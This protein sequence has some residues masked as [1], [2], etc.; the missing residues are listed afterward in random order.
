MDKLRRVGF[1]IGIVCVAYILIYA[2]NANADSLQVYYLDDGN[3]GVTQEC[4]IVITDAEF[5]CWYGAVYGPYSMKDI[6]I[7]KCAGRQ[8]TTVTNKSI[9]M[10]PVAC[11]VKTEHVRWRVKFPRGAEPNP[12]TGRVEAKF[13]CIDREEPQI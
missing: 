3:G 13:Y 2:V 4:Y 8:L 9:R 5:Y 11:E 1:F 12:A 10:R 7:S 6:P